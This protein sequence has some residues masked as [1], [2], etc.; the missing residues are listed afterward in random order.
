[1][2]HN[3]SINKVVNIN[4]VSIQTMNKTK[5]LH[6]GV[7]CALAALAVGPVS[8]Q[9]YVAPQTYP[10]YNRP[11]YRQMYRQRQRYQNRMRQQNQNRFNP[12]RP[13]PARKNNQPPVPPTQF[14]PDANINPAPAIGAGGTLYVADGSP[15]VY[16]VNQKTGK[17][18]WTF[19]TGGDVIATPAVGP[20]GTVYVTSYDHNVYALNG[21]TGAKKWQFQT[22]GLLATT[23]AVGSGNLIYVG[24][25]D[26]YVYAINKSGAKQWQY[27]TGSAVTNPVIGPNGTVYVG[28][29]RIYALNGATGKLKWYFSNGYVGN[30]TPYLDRKNGLLY[31]GAHDGTLYAIHS[32]SG[33]EAWKI[34]T[35]GTI[36]SPPVISPDGLLYFASD[37]LYCVGASDGKQHWAAAHGSFS[38]S[39]PSLS[40]NGILY[41]GCSDQYLYAF[42]PDNG[43]VRWT[44]PVLD[45]LMT[46]P[47]VGPK[48]HIYLTSVGAG[49]IYALQGLTGQTKWAVVPTPPAVSKASS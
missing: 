13:V 39:S 19:Q 37:R 48:D 23:P 26:H 35:N 43:R 33:R 15:A 1:V 3:E 47:A 24:G 44:F 38:W 5:L 28:A 40:S 49:R 10:G 6:I 17:T 20:N 25:Y 45:G 31:V 29:D 12:A 42:D 2:R 9:V 32:V 41:A 8:A 21:T 4:L 11:N 34:P 16:A 7:S 36:V 27:E 18:L 30:D 14:V 22:T 46:A